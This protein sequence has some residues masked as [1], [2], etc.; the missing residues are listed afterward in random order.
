MKSNII[1]AS[2]LIVGI[3]L[4]LVAEDKPAAVGKLNTANFA[5]DKLVAWC[6][7]PFDAKKR[8][9]AERAEMVKRIGMSRVAYDW[10]G[11]HVASFEDE[12][13]QYK[14][15]GIE[16]FAFW[17]WHDSLEPL[18]KKHGIQPQIWRTAP[19][20]D[21]GTQEEKVVAAAKAVLPMVDK[22]RTLGLKYGLYNHGGWGGE[23]ANLVA[24]CEYLRK[25]HD[26]QH[27]GIVYNL[28]HGHG[29]IKDFADSLKLMQPYLLCL[30]VNGMKDEAHKILPVGSGEHDVTMFK[31]ILA[32]GY[33]GP[34][35]ILNHT[36]LDAEVRLKENLYGVRVV[37]KEI[38]AKEK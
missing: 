22:C 19:S 4:H 2:L 30:N 9:P 24:V 11:E 29:H 36:D 31:T 20:P 12:I 32:S 3:D 7:V 10:R 17:D 23:P 15:H 34:I 33:S 8:S 28:H 5:P 37:L 25:H 6:I 14:K 27:V 35:G 1:L 26:A 18:M 13:L 21:D 16:F 38:E